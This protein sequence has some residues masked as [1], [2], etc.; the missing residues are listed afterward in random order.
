MKTIGNKIVIRR[1]ETFKL[2]C[3]IYNRDGVP[4]ILKKG[5][6][7]QYLCIIITSTTLN[8]DK[9]YRCT[10]WLNLSKYLKFKSKVPV[11]VSQ[12]NIDNNTLPDGYSKPLDGY[13]DSCIFYTMNEDTTKTFYYYNGTNYEEYLFTFTKTFLNRDTSDLIEGTYNYQFVVVGGD[14]AE[15]VYYR[16]Y[17]KLYPNRLYIPYGQVDLYNEICKQDPEF[18]KSHRPNV[19]LSNNYYIYDEVS[20]PQL[21]IVKS[22]L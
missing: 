21:L 14:T 22:N 17:K 19:P 16:T 1:G 8:V 10:Y 3:K 18:A 13:L 7:N 2:S 6:P 20:K 9:R 15:D 12:T 4:Y 11:L 5:I